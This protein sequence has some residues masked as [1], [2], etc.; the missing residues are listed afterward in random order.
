MKNIAVILALFGANALR[1]NL[2]TDDTYDD[3]LLQEMD[4]EDD[5][6][7][8]DESLI[9]AS[10]DKKKKKN[11][12]S[13][14]AVQKGMPKSCLRRRKTTACCYKSLMP[15]GAKKPYKKFAVPWKG[16]EICYTSYSGIPHTS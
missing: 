9:E 6:N 10:E 13:K 7:L 12:D 16:K 11:G 14:F 5:L 3:T 8:E 1:L 4:H 15:E 2:E